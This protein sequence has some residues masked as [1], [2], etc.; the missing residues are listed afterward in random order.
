MARTFV[1][2]MYPLV[3]PKTGL[4]TSQWRRFQEGV[5]TAITPG[6]SGEVLTSN[7]TAL[8][9]QKLVNANVDAAA[10][11]VY[12]KLNL[13][14]SIV[15]ADVAVAAAIAW[16]KVSKVGSV[17]SDITDLASGTYTPTL[18]NT[19]NLDGSTAYPC[20]YLR[21][22]ATVTISGKVDVNPT[23]GG[24]TVLGISLP[25]GSDFGAV[26][27][28]G[29]VAFAPGI[30]GQG[31]AILAD[32]ANNRATMQWIAVDVTNQAMHFTFSYQ[33]I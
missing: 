22:G 11:I 32:A 3:D 14:L 25:I 20:Q 27:D 4:I 24:N 6:G 19:T 21:V 2:T 5:G 15:N 1:P 7:G 26:E 29:G 23:A 28:C 12:S 13:A 10:A 31:A 8:V 16:S 33:V 9:W 17:H 18:F 30:A